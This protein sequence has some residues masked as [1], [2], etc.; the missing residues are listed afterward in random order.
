VRAFFDIDVLRGMEYLY[1]TTVNVEE[2]FHD[3]N[4]V[5]YYGGA[6]KCGMMVLFALLLVI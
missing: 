2:C 4:A 5:Y 6:E 3:V 1:A